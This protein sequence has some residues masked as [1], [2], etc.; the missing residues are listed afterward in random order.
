MAMVAAT[1]P[2]TIANL[3]R[4][5]RPSALGAKIVVTSKTVPSTRSQIVPL[6]YHV[7]LIEKIILL[8]QFG[9]GDRATTLVNGFGPGT[10][11]VPAIIEPYSL[12]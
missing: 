7:G 6:I 5:I 1:H 11:L 4:P 3:G 10:C 9:A 2:A 12:S 8:V